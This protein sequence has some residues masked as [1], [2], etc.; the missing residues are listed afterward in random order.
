LLRTLGFPV[1]KELNMRTR[2]NH[3]GPVPSAVRQALLALDTASSSCGVPDLTRALV[4]LR[5]SQ[6]RGCSV[7]IDLHLLKVVEAG[8]DEAR[9]LALADWRHST[10]FREAERAALAL[11]EHL[12]IADQ[13]QA[14]SDDVWAEAKRLYD[15]PALTAL[16]LQI[17]KSNTWHGLIAATEQ[18]MD[19]G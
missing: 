1:S 11:A 13:S 9:V 19:K 10:R 17:T 4:H 8:E 3:P 7:C 14:T 2:T 5:A 16:V 12:T 18:L 15:K 6:I